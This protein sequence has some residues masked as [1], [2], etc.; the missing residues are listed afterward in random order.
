VG[1][2]TIRSSQ[3]VEPA[4]L[5][6]S[7]GIAPSYDLSVYPG[8][9]YWSIEKEGDNQ[10]L[11]LDPQYLQVFAGQTGWT[12]STDVHFLTIRVT[13]ETGALIDTQISTHPYGRVEVT[14][15][16]GLIQGMDYGYH[17]GNITIS[18]RYSQF[19]Q[20]IPVTIHIRQPGESIE[21]PVTSPESYQIRPDYIMIETAAAGILHL[22]LPVPESMAYY[23]TQTACDD[24]QGQWIDP[25]TIP[26]NLNEYCSLNQH[27]YVLMEFPE[28]APGMIYAWNRLGEF[29]LAY[30]NGIKTPEAD[31]FTY[32]DGPVP[33]IPVGPVQLLEY[34][35][36]MIISTRIGQNLN[37][38]VEIQRIQINIRTPEGTWNVTESY[39]G[40]VYSYDS[41]QRLELNRTPGA[42]GYF[43][44]TW[45]STTVNVVPGDGLTWL[46]QIEFSEKG[47]HY[48]YQIQALSAN[49]MSGKWHFSWSG[50]ESSWETFQAHRQML[51][52]RFPMP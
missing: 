34:H 52:P 48:I 12:V 25:D 43:N 44:G 19:F 1:T 35:G 7:A 17:S 42:P 41:S 32:A 4:I 27:V 45:G 26:G 11:D 6:V 30:V 23:P 15:I 2:V 20:I 22:Q 3:M 8:Q 50:G 33:V 37:E 18:D 40:E 24:A 51:L 10:T 47:I 29:S 49:Q 16:A 21:M 31:A 5:T 36:S 14:P 28:M 9:L 39:Q 13:D 38:A 46:H